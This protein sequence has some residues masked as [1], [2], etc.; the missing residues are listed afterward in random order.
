[1]NGRSVGRKKIIQPGAGVIGNRALF[2]IV[3]EPGTLTAV[4]Y[5]EMGGEIGRDELVTADEPSSLQALVEPRALPVRRAGKTASSRLFYIDLALTDREGRTA[6]NIDFDCDLTVDE[7]RNFRILGFGS[8]DPKPKWNYGE[9]RTK[10]FQGRALL[11]GVLENPEQTG[12]VLV[13][14]ESGMYAE[15]VVREVKDHD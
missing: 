12:E 7:A 6:G 1:M 8:A 3:Y 14:S 11:I 5:D 9:G 4:L 13:R 10:T 15:I 2:E